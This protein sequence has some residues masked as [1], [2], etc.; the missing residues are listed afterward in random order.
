MKKVEGWDRNAD[1]LL[2]TEEI[3][4]RY[5][6]ALGAAQSTLL[7]RFGFANAA[8][9]VN[10]QGAPGSATMASAPK[11]FLKMDHNKD[12]DLSPRE[13][14]GPRA[15]FDRIDADHDGLIDPQEAA[16]AGR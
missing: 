2:A 8:F 4:A 15:D 11:W 13:F 14:L 3:P 12:G 5:Q 7:D 9:N 10:M 6:A 1:G 16:K